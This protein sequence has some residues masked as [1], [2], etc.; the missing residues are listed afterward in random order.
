MMI[1]I[2]VFLMVLAL[3]LLLLAALNIGHPRVNLGWLGL[4]FWALSL[5]LR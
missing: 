4:F 2:N 1:T 3:V 5:V